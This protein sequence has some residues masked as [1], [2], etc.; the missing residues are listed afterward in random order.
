MTD[1]WTLLAEATHTI[2]APPHEAAM[3]AAYVLG[4]EI[5]DLI[6][7]HPTWDRYGQLLGEIPT[8]RGSEETLTVRYRCEE[9]GSEVLEV[10]VPCDAQLGCGPAWQT[11]NGRGDLQS[12]L[13]GEA[14]DRACERCGAA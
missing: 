6:A 1:L 2:P 3:C 9:P 13:D 10:A 14:A 8:G 5:A 4:T 12:A 7:W 11:I